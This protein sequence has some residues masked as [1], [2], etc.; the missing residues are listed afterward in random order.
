MPELPDEHPLRTLAYIAASPRGLD[1]GH[2]TWLAQPQMARFAPILSGLHRKAQAVRRQ[3]GAAAPE[4][5]QAFVDIAL[6]DLALVCTTQE[7]NSGRI[8]ATATPKKPG[9]PRKT[10]AA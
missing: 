3:G 8:S 7:R 5:L 10:A 6:A 4:Q 2:R 9:R 1:L